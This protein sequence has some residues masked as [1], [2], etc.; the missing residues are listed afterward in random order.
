MGANVGLD[1]AWCKDCSELADE[2]EKAATLYGTHRLRDGTEV[3]AYEVD[4]YGDSPDHTLFMDDANTPG[5][6]GLPYLG[7]K[8]AP[9]LY[10]ATR[11]AVWRKPPNDYFVSGKWTGIGSPHWTLEGVD[12]KQMIWPLS[13]I[14]RALTS[15]DDAE[16]K[17]SL[18]TLRQTTDDRWFIHESFHM[19]N[20]A[21]FSRP[22]FAWANTLFGELVLDLVK[23]KPH[24]VA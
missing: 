6:L 3:W 12:Q 10:Q 13:L 2:I 9:A 17:L 24:L 22:W 7:Y 14:V 18:D 16:I 20:P 5:L 4:G 11:A 21:I 15:N 23:R 1:A 8:A 19:D